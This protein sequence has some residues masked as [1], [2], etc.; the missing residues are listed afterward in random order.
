MCVCVVCVH[1]MHRYLVRC[2]QTHPQAHTQCIYV[3]VFCVRSIRGDLLYVCIHINYHTRNAF[4]CVCVVCIFWC[5]YLLYVCI[6][7][8]DH[9]RNVFTCAFIVC[10]LYVKLYCMCTYP[11][12][13]THIRN[14][15]YKEMKKHVS[16]G[17]F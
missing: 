13:I 7:I 3:C 2:V 6:H 9:T 16:C 12:I 15:S 10:M 1:I 17:Y 4:I 5:G 11:F 8:H 14:L